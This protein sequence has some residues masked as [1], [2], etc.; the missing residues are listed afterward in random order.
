[1]TAYQKANDIHHIRN[2]N[3]A[4]LE[5]S[6]DLAPSTIRIL[7]DTGLQT[8]LFV[9]KQKSKHKLSLSLTML[10]KLIN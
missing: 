5:I 10:V 2:I 7:G 3:R 1:M 9:I 6:F 4:T 8:L